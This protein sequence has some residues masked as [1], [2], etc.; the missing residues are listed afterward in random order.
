[1]A[2]LPD[3]NAEDAEEILR[4]YMV[5]YGLGDADLI[6]AITAA[7][8]SKKI[9]DNSSLDDIGFAIRDTDAYKR[10]FAGN[11]ALQAKGKPIYSLTEYIQLENKYKQ[12][13]QGSGL[14]AGFYD[15]PDDFA[16]FMANDVSPGEVLDRVQQGF[17]AVKQADK[18]VINQMKQLYGV[19]EGD[20]AAY[21]LDPDKATP[22]LLRRAQAA[23]IGGE[24]MRQA[25]LQLTSQSAEELA[26]QGIEAGTARQGFGAIAAS[27]QIFNPMSAQ[28]EQISL[29]EQMGAVFGTNAA[30]AQRVRQ[31]AAQRTAEFAGGGGFAAEGGTVTGLTNA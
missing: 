5:Y 6:S 7:W 3:P 19:S 29:E 26:A 10:R 9:N 15:S 1:M 21:F 27:Q 2:F 8:R 12:A 22:V 30:A 14:P 31:R 18:A 20:L 25:G 24:A 28:E 17:M 16:G 11:I 4:T 23:Q 13:M